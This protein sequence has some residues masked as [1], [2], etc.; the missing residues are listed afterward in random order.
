M[1]GRWRKRVIENTDNNLLAC[2]K[3]Y[4]F[5]FTIVYISAIN[6]NIRTIIGLF[7]TIYVNISTLESLKIHIIYYD[8]NKSCNKSLAISHA[9]Y[10]I[11]D[12]NAAHEYS[13][14]VL[15]S[16]KT[17]TF[18]SLVILTSISPMRYK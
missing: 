10:T 9:I 13:L 4:V 17:V 5:V 8:R 6:Q 14:S 16:M 12:G 2:L 18:D 15:V 11:N 7:Y 3:F 1:I